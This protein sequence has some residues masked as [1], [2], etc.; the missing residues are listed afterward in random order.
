M[1]WVCYMAVVLV[2]GLATAQTT[3]IEKTYYV[4]VATSA[5]VPGFGHPGPSSSAPNY[6]GLSETSGGPYNVLAAP[7]FT[8]DRKYQFVIEGTATFY[9]STSSSGGNPG[10][11]AINPS[12]PSDVVT[13]GTWSGNA[14]V[15]QAGDTLVFSPTTTTTPDSFYYQDAVETSMGYF[16][17]A[18][19]CVSIDPSP[20]K[21]LSPAN[22]TT[23]FRI[24]TPL[25]WEPVASFGRRCPGDP[26]QGGVS[27]ADVTAG[28]YPQY[29]I[30]FAEGRGVLDVA[31]NLTLAPAQGL[32]DIA[33]DVPQYPLTS[34]S[35][36]PGRT[37]SWAILALNGARSSIS[38]T[39]TFTTQVE[40]VPVN[41]TTLDNGGVLQDRIFPDVP[42]SFSKYKYY[43]IDVDSPGGTLLIV[44]SASPLQVANAPSQ[45]AINLFVTAFNV[46]HPQ[47]TIK[48]P[49]AAG[50]RFQFR[51][52]EDVSLTSRRSVRVPVADAPV[53]YIGVEASGGSATFALTALY[54]C[55][56][57]SVQ[58]SASGTACTA[59]PVN[60][61]ALFPGAVGA[62]SAACRC[63]K[64]FYGP[65]GGPCTRCP[66]GGV[67]DG[68]ELPS[69]TVGFWASPDDRSFFFTCPLPSSCL[70]GPDSRCEEGYEGRLCSN[71]KSGYYKLNS[72]CYKCPSSPGVTFFFGIAI[73]GLFLVLC[74]ELARWYRKISSVTVSINFIQ[75]VAILP[76]YQLKWPQYIKVFFNDLS[77]F[78][79]NPQ[80]TAP[81]CSFTGMSWSQQ[82]IFTMFFPALVA[83]FMSVVYVVVWLLRQWQLAK[84]YERPI[85]TSRAWDIIVPTYVTFLLFFYISIS[86]ATVSFFDCTE[87]GD[88]TFT[89]DASADILCYSSDWFTLLPLAVLG[90]LIYVIG[91][92]V[93]LFSA[94]YIRKNKLYDVSRKGQQM[95]R[96]LGPV[97][98]RFHVRYYWWEMVVFA[99]KLFLI[100]AGSFLTGFTLFQSVTAVFILVV[101]LWIQLLVYPF[102][103]QKANWLEA[104]LNFA[105][106][107]LFLMGILFQSGTL[108]DASGMPEFIFGVAV[109]LFTVC[110][111]AALYCVGCELR[112]VYR[113]ITDED[114]LIMQKQLGK[115]ELEHAHSTAD[116]SVAREAPTL[117]DEDFSDDES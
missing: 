25:V 44:G 73:L 68:S 12:S 62:P 79:L 21:L 107:V 49:T 53:Y 71:C 92:P 85:K 116:V 66:R 31:A 106:I 4:G 48:Q 87:Q 103:Y 6:L 83:A 35:I 45:G 43:S 78:N 46:T 72:Q 20:V 33:P 3:E 32:R 18:I 95:Y 94:L 64:G 59:C 105:L 58:N 9:L 55:P 40:E 93:A 113:P 111:A 109:V 65:V 22:G 16:A 39:F 24:G 75:T 57:T 102:A 36:V 84:S 34:A 60:M 50:G 69:G 42:A 29:R 96:W 99:R 81:E 28:K 2:A 82:W 104:L 97:Y 51:S 37:Y 86:Q 88:N 74:V 98:L 56:L 8:R 76:L 70:G 91:I 26:L 17:Q 61:E 67:C 100:A 11:D 108:P 90:F 52:Q 15:G 80:L 14:H 27:A 101:A 7:I 5:G 41:G 1:Y 38:P 112:D 30:L 13:G 114:L 10:V 115:H 23:N 54:Q 117:V 77:G 110:L 47:Q 63:Q 89:L 19:D